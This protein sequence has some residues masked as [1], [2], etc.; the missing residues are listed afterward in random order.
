MKSKALPSTMEKPCET[1]KSH[2]RLVLVKRALPHPDNAPSCLLQ[3]S[4]HLLISRTVALQFCPPKPQPSFWNP[5]MTRATVP[6]AAIHE[7]RDALLPPR[8]VRLS[9]Q[10]HTTA[11]A[12][13]PA[14]AKQPCHPLLGRF[15]A[16]TP[17]LSHAARPFR[18]VKRVGHGTC[19]QL[20]D[21]SR[22]V[23]K[24]RL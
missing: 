3:N 4:V 17:H 1:S 10:L 22:S 14:R 16:F 9:R 7:K 19:E 2:F 21:T 24:S 12:A 15:I 13:Q 20:P 8:K 11:P 6:E 18:L 5:S 23:P